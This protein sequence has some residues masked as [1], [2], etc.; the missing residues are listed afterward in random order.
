M[1]GGMPKPRLPRE[2]ILG[3]TGFGPDSAGI[4]GRAAEAYSMTPIQERAPVD[5]GAASGSV[6]LVLVV[7]LALVG[8]AI[9]LL[10]VGRERARQLDRGT[11]AAG[12]ERRI[13]VG[14]RMA[15]TRLAND[16]VVERKLA[17]GAGADSQVIAELPVVQVVPAGVPFATVGRNF[18]VAQP[19][20]GS[21]VLDQLL[22]VGGEF[23]VGQRRWRMP[24][25]SVR[26]GER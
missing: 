22:H 23:V 25:H 18:V 7:A 26:A 14:A 19:R 2:G 13:H 3:Q 8:L 9:F 24:C 5:R 21:P 10:I 6:G 15:Q 12:A 20:C 1:D 11:A 16:P 17:V 4:P